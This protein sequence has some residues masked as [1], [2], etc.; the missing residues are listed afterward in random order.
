MDAIIYRRFSSDEQEK[1]SSDTLARQQER[2][3][4]L[5]VAR[6]WKVAETITDRGLSAFRGEHLRPDAGLG[7]FLERLRRGDFP[8]GTVLI[9]DNLSRLSRRPVDEAMAWIYEVTRA[10]VQIAIADTQEVFQANPSMGD[11]LA[12]SIKAAFS[13]EDSRRKSDMTRAS[14]ARLWKMAERKEGRWTSLAGLLPSW[15]A[16]TPAA[17]G[18]VVDEDRAATVRTIYQLSADGIGVNTIT[19]MLNEQGIPPLTKPKVYKTNEPKWG[20]SSV[21][22]LLTSPIVEGDFRPKAGGM[23]EGRVL[24]DFYPRIVD[25]DLIAR[26]RLE[27]TARRKVRGKA[28]SSGHAN[29]FA[30][31]TRCG[32]CHRRASLST[33]VQKG[34][35]Y[36]YVRCEAA[37]EGR[38]DN[39]NGYAYR[40]FEETALDLL[41]D[42]ALDDRFF[43]A[44]SALREVRIRKAEIEKAI[45][46]KRA[47]RERL[48]EAFGQADD[49]PQALGIIAKRKREIDDLVT[50]L[51]EVEIE[52]QRA[53]G[54]VGNVEHLRRVGDIRKAAKSSNENDRIQ[55]RSKLRLALSAI[56][57]VVEI[58]RD[59][60]G[61]KVFTV[62]LKGG[63]MAVRIN[64]KGVVKQA[65]SDALGKPL[66][67]YLPPS[68]QQALAP[69]I[70][71]IESL[72]GRSNRG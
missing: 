40:A 5:A 60:E 34:K 69:I 62:I 4:A 17:D 25:A 18:F 26:A 52:I 70:R 58:E 11:F 30:G 7:Q 39:K 59:S 22:Q 48:M 42:L 67:T 29:L 33:S 66:W 41:L 27:L 9:A 23:F 24:H 55:A 28:A 36:P 31:F 72:A 63:I 49:D 68:Q 64:T 10:G 12:T 8:T 57:M 35:A 38:C 14:K 47:V 43:E 16:R 61:E 50:E 56:V 44:T 32:V 71:R 21:R 65:V 15:L 54:R 46:N 37:Q 1:G 13:H 45:T 20:R 51:A 19:N 53:A 6:G 3:E 2:C